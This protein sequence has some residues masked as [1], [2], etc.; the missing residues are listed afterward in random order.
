MHVVCAADN[1]GEK[2]KIMKVNPGLPNSLEALLHSVSTKSSKTHPKLH[3]STFSV[4]LRT[5]KAKK[6][7]REH[8][9]QRA[10][11]VIYKPG[12]NF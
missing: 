5:D 12:N 4:D 10:I 2:H 6:L 3:L 1:W 8:R 9:L 7:L 11:G